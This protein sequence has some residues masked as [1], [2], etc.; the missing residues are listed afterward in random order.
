MA[1]GQIY[2]FIISPLILLFAVWQTVKQVIFFSKSLPAR[3]RIIGLDP[4][5][6]RYRTYYFLIVEFLND[7][8][9]RQVFVGGLGSTR[10]RESLIGRQIEVRY[11]PGGNE[12]SVKV[13]TFW[14]VV[15]PLLVF[16]AT[17]GWLLWL[18]IQGGPG[19]R[20]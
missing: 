5:T 6:W 13:W 3:G 7:K 16:F 9:E 19:F 14:T 20:I 2:F 11:Y 8:H 1:V 17:G 18:A 10:R 4:Q 15:F 12:K